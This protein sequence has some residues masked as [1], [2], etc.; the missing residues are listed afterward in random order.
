MT[1]RWQTIVIVIGTLLIAAVAV[2]LL[3]EGGDRQSWL[4]FI[5][6]AGFLGGALA[7]LYRRRRR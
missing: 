1:L 4:W 5:I 3:V 7:R 6:A 2:I